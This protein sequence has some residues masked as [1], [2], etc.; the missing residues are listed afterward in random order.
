[1]KAF[2]RYLSVK[3]RTRTVGLPSGPDP[4]EPISY[5][6]G[7]CGLPCFLAYMQIPFETLKEPDGQQTWEAASVLQLLQR[8]YGP[9]DPGWFLWDRFVEYVRLMCRLP[10][11]HEKRE[12]EG[13]ANIWIGAINYDQF[14]EIAA[15]WSAITLTMSSR[16]RGN[17]GPV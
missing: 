8:T 9:F 10:Y 12:D 7:V 1:M 14:F 5:A 3:K 11:P 16:G 6:S 13:V 17:S 4:L 2:L 15:D